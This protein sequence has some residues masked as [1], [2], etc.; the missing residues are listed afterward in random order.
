M[1]PLFILLTIISAFFGNS[2]FANDE[3]NVT[4][5]VRKSFQRSFIDA[6][7][8]HWVTRKEFYKAEFELNGES[9][10]AYYSLEGKFLAASK[11]LR[12]T[13][14]PLALRADIKKE[15][16]NFWV[17]DLFELSSEQE[18]SYF[19]TLEDADTKLV[20]KS[21]GNGWRTYQKTTK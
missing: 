2:A 13:Q 11:N 8:V 5:S 9:M 1:K 17:T 21:S 3:K 6:K 10:R 4:P 16:V 7:E 18:T 15:Y 14:L 19:I 20:L 12:T